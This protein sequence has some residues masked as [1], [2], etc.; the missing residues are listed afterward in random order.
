M[1]DNPYKRNSGDQ[2]KLKKHLLEAITLDYIN[3]G[4]KLWD[5]DFL[6]LVD[7]HWRQVYRAR[8]D[9]EVD[10]DTIFQVRVIFAQC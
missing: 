2:P 3:E 4:P 5:E 6:R 1:R 7:R 9:E 8:A 10:E